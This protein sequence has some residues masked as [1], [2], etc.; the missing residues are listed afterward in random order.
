MVSDEQVASLKTN[1]DKIKTSTRN[2]FEKV[3]VELENINQGSVA[4]NESFMRS[5]RGSI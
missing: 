1:A 5:Q 4:L 3:R 2:A